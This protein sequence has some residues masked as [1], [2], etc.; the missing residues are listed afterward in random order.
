M[1]WL[2]ALPN[3][4]LV[5]HDRLVSANQLIVRQQSA[6]STVAP[7]ESVPSLTGLRL[8]APSLGLRDPV[9][10][11]GPAKPGEPIEPV[12][13]IRFRSPLRVALDLQIP[14][15]DTYYTS[16]P[17]EWAVE[18]VGGYGSNIAGGPAHG[19]WDTT[20]GKG[21]RI[22][23]LD[24]GVDEAHPDIAPNLGL[25]LS[26]VDQ[27][28]LPSACDDGTPQDQQGHGTWAASLAAGALGPGTGLT[29]GV[30][31]QATVLNIKVMERLPAGDGSDPATQ[32][33]AGEASGLLSW[34]L[35]GIDDAMANGADVIS[36]SLGSVVDVTTGDGAGL[37]ALFDQATYAAATQ[38]A[39]LIAAAGNNGL[40]VT[41]PEFVELPAQSRDVLAIVASTNPACAENLTA[42][43]VCAPGPVTLAY[44]SD[45]GAAL[46]ALAAPGGSLPDGSDTGVSGWVRGACSG[47][48]P[49]TVDGEPVDA[50][51]SYGCFNLGHTQYVQAMGTSAAAPLAA[52]VAALL[53][54]A[55]P[56]WD[57]ATVIAAMRSGATG[58]TTL[59]V[60]LVSAAGVAP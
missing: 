49:G 7:T 43:A 39:V 26:E 1:A 6:G 56:G 22:A 28:A 5:L 16:T 48:K 37:Q 33:E 38:G 47:G 10:P 9:R 45:Y 27:T 46:D 53:R 12:G 59:P 29:V 21:V 25:N 11:V 52:G 51:H 24:S 57:A 18:Q 50:T 17:Q 36:M 2:Q 41:G 60:G 23:I 42:G 13:P 15:Y 3:V 40:E 34:V 55:H 32:C 58:V 44:Y 4:A 14:P 20:M 35:A 31:P 8:T 30:A 19:P 54:A